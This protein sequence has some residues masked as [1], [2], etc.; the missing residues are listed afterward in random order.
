[1]A[2]PEKFLAPKQRRQHRGG[3]RGRIDISG[4]SGRKDCRLSV[5]V[6]GHKF[7]TLLPGIYFRNLEK[8]ARI[9]EV[10]KIRAPKPSGSRKGTSIDG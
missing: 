8:M 4:T 5:A 3:I 9:L 7:R 1:M 6:D 2:I 10:R